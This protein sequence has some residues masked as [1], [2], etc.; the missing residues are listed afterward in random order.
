MG[1][2][3]VDVPSSADEEVC[4]EAEHA[5][6]IKSDGAS[7][8]AIIKTFVKSYVKGHQVAILSAQSGTSD[9]IATLDRELTMLSIKRRGGS[10]Q[11]HIPLETIEEISIGTEA[12]DEVDL[13]LDDNSV[14]L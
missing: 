9:C 6:F 7:A 2:D 1:G 13:P 10:K 4:Q 5:S 12:E 11:R 8:K 3:D 14:A